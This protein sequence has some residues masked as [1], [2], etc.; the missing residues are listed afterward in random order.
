MFAQ[1][2]HIDKTERAHLNC[3]PSNLG[4]PVKPMK[5]AFGNASHSA[6]QS[7]P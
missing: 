7:H 5:E 2:Q 1:L 6:G 4:V 3:H